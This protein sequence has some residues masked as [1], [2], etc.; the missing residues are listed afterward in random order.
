ML[1]RVLGND[2]NFSSHVEPNLPAIEA[3]TAATGNVIENAPLYGMQIG[4]GPYLRDIVATGNVIRNTGTGIAVSVVE[5]SGAAVLTDNVID[6]TKKGAI[7]GQ[8]WADP[9]TGDLAV[10]GSDGYPHLTVER[11]RAR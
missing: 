4:W 5:G 8:R 6:G 2:V 11:N 10:E 7:L 9:V 3:D 1:A